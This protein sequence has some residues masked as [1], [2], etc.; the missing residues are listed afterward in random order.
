MDEMRVHNILTFYL[1]F[2]I[3]AGF[4]YE[5]LNRNSK[6]LVYV[7]A[8]LIAY[9][10][11]RLEI[12]HYTHKWSAHRDPGFVR[13]LLIYDLFALGFLLPTLLA[14]STKET[15]IRNFLIYIVVAFLMYVPISRMVNRL[16]G[17]LVLSL[18]SSLA[19]FI[20]THGILEPGIFA[21]L[22]LWTYLALKHGLVAH[23]G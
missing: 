18:G 15:F 3:L 2:L 16:S 1:P 6:A 23:A 12:H 10:A 7:S 13:I 19:I 5:F 17:V 22:G 21:L 9:L 11:I 14:Y 8:Y 20:I 4:V